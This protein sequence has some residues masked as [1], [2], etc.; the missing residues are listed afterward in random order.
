[1]LP[2]QSFS[3]YSSL[4]GGSKRLSLGWPNDLMRGRSRRGHLLDGHPVSYLESPIDMIFAVLV[5][6]RKGTNATRSTDLEH[7][8]VVQLGTAGVLLCR[9]PA[10][11]FSQLRRGVR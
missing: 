9:C 3:Q 10:A 6:Y 8:V 11:H 4:S 7:A 2:Q 5:R 1:M